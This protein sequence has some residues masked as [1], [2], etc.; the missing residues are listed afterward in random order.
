[1]DPR[2]DADSHVAVLQAVAAE[3]NPG[4]WRVRLAAH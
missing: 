1:M 2:S 3:H 4:G